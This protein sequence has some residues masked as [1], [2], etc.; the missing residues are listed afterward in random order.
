MIESNTMSNMFAPDP[1]ATAPQPND[2]ASSP[3]AAGMS[4]DELTGGFD[5]PPVPIGI[6][7][8]HVTQLRQIPGKGFALDVK[9]DDPAYPSKDSVGLFIGNDMGMLRTIAGSLGIA[10]QVQDGKVYFSDSEGKRDAA[11]FKDKTGLFI[12]VPYNSAP[13]IGRFGAPAKGKSE[14]WD[15]YVEERGGFNDEQIAALKKA[16]GGVI[17]GDLI[18]LFE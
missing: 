2:A 17:P 13:A 9:C 11:A 5:L 6:L 18:H 14:E 12:F 15:Q 16:R 4:S 10:H 8:G 7:R 1:N 3:F